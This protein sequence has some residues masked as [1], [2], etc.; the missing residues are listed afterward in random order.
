MKVKYLILGAGPAGLTFANKLLE[1]GEDDFLVIEKEDIAGGLCKSVFVDGSELDVGGGHFLDVRRPEVVDFL[2][3]FMPEE[4]W[5]IF[6]RDSQIF[7]H[8]TYIGHPFEAN[9]WQLPD[10]LQQM[11]LDSIK[12]AGCNRNV[13]KPEKFTEWIRWKLGDAIADNYMLPYNLKMYGDL[14]DELGTYWLDKLPNV[15]YE[16]TLK[17]C[18]ERRPFGSQPGHARFYYPK[19]YGFGEVFRRMAN[20]LGDK[21]ICNTGVNKL[22]INN[23]TVNDEFEASYIITTIPWTSIDSIICDDEKILTE[24]SNLKHTGIYVD[25]FKGNMDTAAQWIYY[26]E[27]SVVFHRILVRHNFLPGSS[28]YWTET[29]DKRHD[30][31]GLDS[32][33]SYWNEYAYPLNIIG[34]NESIA[35]ILDYC[36]GHNVIG[37]GRWGEWQ[38]F[39]ADAVIARSLELAK[40]LYN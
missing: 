29:R 36:S 15:S 7:I 11:Y 34:K 17:S 40:K 33:F 31:M 16:D 12:A 32:S 20:R 6:D 25:Y 19:E 22:D 1:M 2:F 9:I 21:L 13:E 38:H 24:I 35:G 26:P 37:L 39:N 18:R 27:E 10:K 8:D 23:R 5:N 28:G 4:E 30:E 14:L 3:Q